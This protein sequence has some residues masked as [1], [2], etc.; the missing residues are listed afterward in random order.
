VVER[1]VNHTL[2]KLMATYNQFEY[3]NERIAAAE[4]L[5]AH[6]EELINV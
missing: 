4:S 2:P 3:E 5:S 1:Y 6:V